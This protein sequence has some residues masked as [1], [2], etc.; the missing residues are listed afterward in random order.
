MSKTLS[1]IDTSVLN[2]DQLNA[3]NELVAY[4][5]DKN[6]FSMYRLKGYAGTGKTFCVSLIVRY[7]LEVIY[8]DNYWYNIAVTGTTNKS[9]R[10]IRKSTGVY[11]NRVVYS[12]IH[13][14]LGLTERITS[15][16][17]QEFVKQDNFKPP[18]ES[19]NLLF[20]DEVSMLDDDL[21][22]KILPYRDKMKIVFIGDGAQIPPINRAN[23][24]PFTDELLDEYEIK[25]VELQTMM[26]QSLEN[27]IVRESVRVRENLSV[28]KLTP[29]IEST[30]TESGDGIE[31]V[32]LRSSTVSDDVANLL[33]RYFNSAEFKKD[34][35]YAKIIAWQNK[36]VNAMNNMVRRLIYG[37][38]A[39]QAKLLI[40]E[41]LIANEPII[42]NKQIIFNTNDEFT[43]VGLEVK[44]SSYKTE[45]D[46]RLKYY[47]VCVESFEVDD[48]PIRKYIDILH[49]DSQSEFDRVANELKRVAISKKGKD[50]S[51][52]KY[53][54]FIR[55]FANVNYAY[56]LTIHKSQGS[57]YKVAIVYEDDIDKNW[58]VVERNRIKYTA[59]TRASNKL[60]ILKKL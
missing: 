36:T 24:I 50:R 59:F 1:S 33:D 38:I 46:I 4:I 58:N 40:G 8:P 29:S 20:I 47:E 10:V 35:E 54:D 48:K 25:S 27:P 14:M 9:V 39:N 45:I 26:R 57:T 3:F 60:Y 32:N 43:V 37:E 42:I 52:I 51:W 11:S 15:D 55:S 41:K 5:K 49:E 21:F 56:S 13:K 12:T 44:E 28:G 16:G 6:D 22:M 23:C 34:S 7:V 2:A 30:L 17:K 18:I 53:Y 31:I 19:I